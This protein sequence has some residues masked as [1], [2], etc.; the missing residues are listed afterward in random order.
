MQTLK[1]TIDLSNK[2]LAEYVH[3]SEVPQHHP[4]LITPNR[5][6]WM[7]RNRF[8]N[9][10]NEHVLKIGN[11]LYVHLPSFEVWLAGQRGHTV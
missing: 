8:E 10:L 4:G 3:Y 1:P 7:I 11:A 2:P 9:G 5:I 6:Q